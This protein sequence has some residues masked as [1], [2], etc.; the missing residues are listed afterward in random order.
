M[1]LDLLSVP[2]NEAI[3]RAEAAL[4]A[5]PPE[6]FRPVECPLTHH[7]APGVY[8]REIFMPAGSVVIGHA[9]RTSHF[10]IILRGRALVTAGGDP[11]VI[12]APFTFVSEPGVRKTL[13]VEEDMIWQ[14]VHVNPDDETCIEVLESRYI[15]KSATYLQHE[16]DDRAF[17]EL[18][19]S[20]S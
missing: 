15:E 9:H 16:E 5:M 10:N 17:L 2:T 14:T 1:T 13:L 18:Q 19:K 12:Q 7:F 8:L 3:E 4:L 6:Q 20:H 11:M